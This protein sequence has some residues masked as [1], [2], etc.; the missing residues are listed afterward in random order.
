MAKKILFPNGVPEGYSGEEEDPGFIMA[1]LLYIATYLFPFLFIATTYFSVKNLFN[2]EYQLAILFA[3]PFAWIAG[4][5]ISGIIHWLCDTYGSVDTPLFGHTLIRN[6]RS[7]HK[8]PKDICVSPLPFIVGYVAIVGL[9]TL[10]PLIFFMSK[11]PNSFI[12]NIFAFTFAIITFLTV[13]TN[14][15]H[16]WA[17]ENEVPNWVTILQKNKIILSPSH[18]IFHHTNP[19]NS[20]YCITHGLTN[21]FLEKIGFFRNVEKTLSKIG[22]NPSA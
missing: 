4:D 21:P 12:I 6:F 16:K 14:Q 18:H 9:I 13:L 11:S 22:I 3:F 17:H 7:H 20:N 2:N 15:F 1:I 19:F 5:F 8:Y 10:P